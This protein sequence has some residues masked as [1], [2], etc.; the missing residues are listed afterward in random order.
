MIDSI[1]QYIN[2]QISPQKE[3][4]LR[5]HDI[6][7]SQYPDIPEKMKFGVPY[8]GKSFYLVA[9]KTHVNLGVTIENLSKEEI[10]QFEGSGKTTRHIKIADISEIIDSQIMEKLD[11]VMR[12]K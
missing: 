11:I 5:L 7:T 1:F 9:L 2:K 3:I 4:L 10:N 6:I 12:K 8:Y